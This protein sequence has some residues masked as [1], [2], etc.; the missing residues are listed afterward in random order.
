M[1][2]NIESLASEKYFLECMHIQGSVL[3]DSLLSIICSR[4][5]NIKHVLSLPQTCMVL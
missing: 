3:R 5:M 2:I 4:E 1:E